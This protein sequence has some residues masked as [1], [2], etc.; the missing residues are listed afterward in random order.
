M[1]CFIR[2]L[3]FKHLERS[4]TGCAPNTAVVPILRVVEC[5]PAEYKVLLLAVMTLEA[6]EVWE[7]RTS[8]KWNMSLKL[9]PT[10]PQAK[11]FIKPLSEA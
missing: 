3:Q 4:R 7:S 1:K 2:I 9:T 5:T 8:L 6:F 11:V 10:D